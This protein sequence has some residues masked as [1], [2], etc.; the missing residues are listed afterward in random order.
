M[1]SAFEEID[2]G[3]T[4]L[5]AIPISIRGRSLAPGALLRAHDA[6]PGGGVIRGLLRPFKPVVMRLVRAVSPLL[7]RVSRRPQ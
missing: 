7:V 1:V 2:P 6:E 3:D 4:G 5:P